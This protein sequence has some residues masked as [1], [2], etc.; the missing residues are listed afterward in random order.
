MTTHVD[1]HVL[2]LQALLVSWLYDGKECYDDACD[3]DWWVD[4]PFDELTHAW[5]DKNWYVQLNHLITEY[6]QEEY[7]VR[8]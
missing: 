7:T 2:G 8:E 6:E 1:K 4:K 3:L 5:E